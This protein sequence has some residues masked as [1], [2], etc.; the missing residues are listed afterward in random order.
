MKYLE[1]AIKYVW[2]N[3]ITSDYCKG[4]V[5]SMPSVSTS[6]DCELG[7][8]HQILNVSAKIYEDE[9]F[10]NSY[11]WMFYLFI[12]QIMSIA[13]VNEHFGTMNMFLAYVHKFKDGLKL[14]HMTVYC[15]SEFK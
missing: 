10:V 4:L 13:I 12:V 2:I 6:C 3:E 11:T 7:R 14:L 8:T 5:H 15:I 1:L 9:S